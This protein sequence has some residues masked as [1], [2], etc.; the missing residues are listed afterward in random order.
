MFD[1]VKSF[2]KGV[3]NRGGDSGSKRFNESSKLNSRVGF[4]PSISLTDL[5]RLTASRIKRLQSSFRR[6]HNRVLL[7]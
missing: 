1:F 4:I 5:E 6:E 3:G 2:E 7:L